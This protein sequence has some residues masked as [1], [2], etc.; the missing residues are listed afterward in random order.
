MDASMRDQHLNALTEDGVARF[1]R[2]DKACVQKFGLS[3]IE[4]SGVH[5][6]VL[7]PAIWVWTL[8]H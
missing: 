1:S 2:Q 8:Y 7:D 4:E 6:I 5:L 3:P